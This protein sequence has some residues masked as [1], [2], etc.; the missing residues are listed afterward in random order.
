M[1]SIIQKLKE[2][3][4]FSLINTLENRHFQRRLNNHNFTILCPNCIG[5]VI[6]SRLGE[7]FNSPT[8]NMHMPTEDFCRFLEQFDY[9][10]SQD[11]ESCGYRDDGVPI[12]KI[13]GQNNTDDITIYFI[14]YKSFEKAREKWNE[15][16]Q[17]IVKDNIYVIMYDINDLNKEKIENDTDRPNAECLKKV[18]SFKCNNKVLL[19]S[20]PNCSAEWSH[21]IEPDYNT[22]YPLVYLGRDILGL[23]VFEK[24]FDFVSFLNKK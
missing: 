13:R 22:P 20:D 8:V 23:R 4:V 18:E 7:R 2:S 19:T 1:S 10:I 24:K 15:R 17:R 11:I 14:H 9:Y 12:G 5:G 3:K 6:Y 16:K 21:Y